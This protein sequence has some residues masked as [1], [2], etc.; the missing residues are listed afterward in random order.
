MTAGIIIL[1]LIYISI[2]L[3]SSKY[4]QCHYIYYCSTSSIYN[5]CEVLKSTFTIPKYINI[6]CTQVITQTIFIVR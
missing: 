2:V 3:S 6:I 1:I 4:T 5:R